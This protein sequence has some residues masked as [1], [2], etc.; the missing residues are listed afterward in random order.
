MV[1]AGSELTKYGVEVDREPT[2]GVINVDRPVA[3]HLKE[4][5]GT[6]DDGTRCGGGVVYLQPAGHGRSRVLP[7]RP[8][9]SHLIQRAATSNDGSRRGIIVEQLP[10]AGRS[11]VLP[12]RPVAVQLE[13]GNG[14][15]SFTP[16]VGTRMNRVFPDER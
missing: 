15:G 2:R 11:R 8:V 5:A 1:L 12:E 14:H 6:G 9:G 13:E 4:A 7:D 16:S 10:T 3:V